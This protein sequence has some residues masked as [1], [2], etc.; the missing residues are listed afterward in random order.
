LR[1]LGFCR[2]PGTIQQAP[3][4]LSEKYL[5]ILARDLVGEGRLERFRAIRQ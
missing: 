2:V 5:F 3:I 1:R 4:V